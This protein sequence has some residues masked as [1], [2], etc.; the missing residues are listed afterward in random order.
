MKLSCL[1][2]NMITGLSVVG[3]AV[4]SGGSLP[5]LQ[6]VRLEADN[7]LLRITGYDLSTCIVTNIASMI[8]EEGSVVV[9]Y[10]LLYNHVKSIP[11]DRLDFEIVDDGQGV[12]QL[13]VKSGHSSLRINL[14]AVG[15]YPVIPK[16]DE[17]LMHRIAQPTLKEALDMTE[18]C[19]ATE[20]SRPVLQ[21][22]SVCVKEG[23]L[24]TA[25]ADGFRLAVFQTPLPNNDLD[26]FDAIIPYWSVQHL[27]RIMASEEKVQI[28]LSADNTQLYFK[29][30]RAQ[31]VSQMLLGEFPNY[32]QLL[33]AE[34]GAV[35]TM[36]AADFHAAAYCMSHL[37]KDGSNVVRLQVEESDPGYG[38]GTGLRT[39]T[40]SESVGAAH[41][42]VAFDSVQRYEVD[43]ELD[44]G[45]IRIAVNF[46]YLLDAGNILNGHKMALGVVNSSSPLAFWATDLPEGQD[47]KHVVMPM[48]VQW[49]QEG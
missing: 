37:A 48:Y 6:C 17:N 33:P 26:G 25:A 22:V 9:P 5:I 29:S 21:G 38:Y 41:M 8:E 46:Q 1:S 30:T 12:E 39:Y 43:G 11:S 49:D 23:V 3:K 16:I 28:G 13:L 35:I 36:E 32:S 2:E 34:F 44:N 15:D 24:T 19:T 31:M 42:M 40:Q 18:F 10:R 7:G 14:G 47:F 20:E 4:P 45:P 27:Q